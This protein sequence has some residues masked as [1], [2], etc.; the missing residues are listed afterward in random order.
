MDRIYMNHRRG[1]RRIHVEIEEQEIAELLDSR[2]GAAA[3]RL[4]EILRTAQ[5]A[6]AGGQ[7]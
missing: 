6:F 7:S 3:R 2:D 1:E 4:D 5:R